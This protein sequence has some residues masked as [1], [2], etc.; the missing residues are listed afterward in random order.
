MKIYKKN[1]V[2]DEA[3]DR[4]RFVYD[5]FDEVAVSFSGG[6]DSTVILELALIVAKEKNRL[7]VPLMFVDQEAEWTFTIDY[8]RRQ[9][10]RD[11]IKPYWLQVPFKLENAAS[12]SGKDYLYCWEPGAEWLREKDPVAIKENIY[13]TEDGK[14]VE[15]YELFKAWGATTYPDIKLARLGGLRAEESPVRYINVTSSPCYKWVTWGTKQRLDHHKLFYPIYDWSYTDIWKA[16]Y[17][18]QWDYCKLYDIMYQHGTSIQNMRVSSLNHETAI[19]SLWWMQEFDPELHSKMAAR[20]DGVDAASKMPESC[21]PPKKLPFMF[22]DWTEYRGHLLENLIDSEMSRDRFEKMFAA[23]DRDIAR[24]SIEGK[25]A[26]RIR[27][28]EVAAI[29]VN[30]FTGTKMHNLKEKILI[31]YR[32]GGGIKDNEH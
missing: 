18:H 9:M 14:G 3:L 26:E 7:P 13:G 22:K 25:D 17:E 12:H 11:E 29:L 2:F 5:E 27:R 31:R 10:Y 30:D 21:M 6:K 23:D 24:F 20:L 32:D 4:I 8:V 28:G 1:N 15:F 16:I 19:R